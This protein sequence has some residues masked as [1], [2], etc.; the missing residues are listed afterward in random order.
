MVNPIVSISWS[1][2]II[3]I[4]IIALFI[5]LGIKLIRY[6]FKVK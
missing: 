3:S 1:N 6:I 4:L 2:L 5:Y